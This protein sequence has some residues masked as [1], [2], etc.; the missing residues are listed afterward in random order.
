MRL[1]K[2]QKLTW[3]KVK[4]SRVTYEAVRKRFD[5]AERRMEKLTAE[6]RQ[7]HEDHV[8][9]CKAHQGHF[10]E[11]YGVRFKIDGATGVPIPTPKP[12]GGSDG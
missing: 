3:E 2:K 9:W 4:E 12:D 8:A 7:A 5:R 6:Y 1:T 10:K 11:R